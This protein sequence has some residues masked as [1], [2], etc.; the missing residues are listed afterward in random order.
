MF[1]DREIKKATE[2]ERSV[3]GQRLTELG[4][5]LAAPVQEPRNDDSSD[6][7]AGLCMDAYEFSDQLNRLRKALSPIDDPSPQDADEVVVEV[8]I[9]P[10]AQEK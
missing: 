7:Y 9:H 3:I 1:E 6:R 4:K 2:R 8:R 10:P 5:W